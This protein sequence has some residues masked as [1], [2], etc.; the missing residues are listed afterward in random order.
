MNAF[1]TEDTLAA[2]ATSRP[3]LTLLHCV[4]ITLFRSAIKRGIKCQ[5]KN[6]KVPKEESECWRSEVGLDECTDSE[7]TSPLYEIQHG[8]AYVVS[9]N[10]H[11]VRV[12][13]VEG[14]GRNT[15]S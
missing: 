8:G 5:N 11:C 3:C 7:G 4:I 13:L 15:P 6:Q 14:I 10:D 1:S 2:H 12:L 9:L